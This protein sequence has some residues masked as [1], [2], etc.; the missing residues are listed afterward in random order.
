MGRGRS[1]AGHK[2]VP[3]K[4]ARWAP[5][6]NARAKCMGYQMRKTGLKRNPGLG[7]TWT[8]ADKACKGQTGKTYTPAG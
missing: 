1:F 4:G 2:I 7:K 8:D 6:P 5:K 3:P